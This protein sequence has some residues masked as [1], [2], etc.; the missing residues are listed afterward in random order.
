MKLADRYKVD[1]LA[2][3]RLTLIDAVEILSVPV[4]QGG[5]GFQLTIRSHYQDKDI[6]EACRPTVLAVFQ[7]QL[8]QTEDELRALGV[9]VDGQ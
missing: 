5:G 6:L 9:E 1:A 3:K 8:R 4:E 7:R 2:S